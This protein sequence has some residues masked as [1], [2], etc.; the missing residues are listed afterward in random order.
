MST[1][2]DSPPPPDP[3]TDEAIVLRCQL[4]E[5]DAFDAL[6]AR[7]HP[8]VWRYLSRVTGNRDAAADAAQDVWLGVVRGIARLR[9]ATKFRP[10]IFGIARRTVMD[11]LR[12]Q[13]AAPAMDPIEVEDIPHVDAADDADDLARLDDELDRLP[14]IEREVLTLFYLRELSL[15]EIAG[16]TAVPVGTVK[17]RLFRARQQLRARLTE[18]RTEP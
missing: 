12:A 4:G 15:V 6:V 2:P 7:W 11:R 9:D 13:Y 18:G 8:L 10:W 3:R 14:I 17:S 5:R 1:V 16:I